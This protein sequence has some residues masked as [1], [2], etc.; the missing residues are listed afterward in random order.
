MA[1]PR[2]IAMNSSNQLIVSTCTAVY[3]IDL[4]ENKS[5]VLAGKDVA[6]FR[7]GRLEDSLFDH[8]D[9]VVCVGG[10]LVFVADTYN[11]R[12]R[13]IDLESAERT[14]TTFAVW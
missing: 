11:H 14:V 3:M 10:N 2:G 13:V 5:S 9:G 6:G 12:I 4:E 8:P 1:E 7:D